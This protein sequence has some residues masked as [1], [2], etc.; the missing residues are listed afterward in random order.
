MHGV[1]YCDPFSLQGNQDVGEKAIVWTI[2]QRMKFIG[3]EILLS[4]SDDI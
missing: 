1:L 2:K 4:Q 3:I